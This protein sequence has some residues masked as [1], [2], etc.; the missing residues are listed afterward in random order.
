M[1][2]AYF[3]T[4]MIKYSDQELI[5]TQKIQSF[6]TWFESQ[7]SY[8][9]SLLQENTD[10]ED[11][12]FEPL[13]KALNQIQTDLFFLL[14]YKVDEQ[15][16]LILTA[17][18]NIKN[19]FLIDALIM[20]A[21]KIPDW[22]IIG[23]KKPIELDQL[24]INIGAMV[25]D[26]NTLFFKPIVHDAYPDLIDIE[27]YFTQFDNEDI[28][29]VHQGIFI[30]LDNYIGELNFT[31][32][33]D[34]VVIIEEVP[35]DVEELVPIGKLKDYLNWREKE[36]LEVYELEL[37]PE[38]FHY[39]LL[40]AELKDGGILLAIINTDALKLPARA[41]LPWVGV[42]TLTFDLDEDLKFPNE[43]TQEKLEQ[44]ELELCDNLT[45][46]DAA[47]HIGR[48]TIGTKREIYFVAADYNRLAQVFYACADKH[49]EFK[50]ESEIYKDKYWRTFDKF[51]VE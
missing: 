27:I 9:K 16:E 39:T 7:A 36:F 6:W 20:H 28:N 3:Y 21:P 1:Q 35:K 11:L 48:Q 26:Q 33:I 31:K 51:C 13:G 38:E 8:F 40:S 41:A 29:A 23:H 22:K 19:M 37:L 24:Q 10:V 43:P 15:A 12:I 17:D 46:K 18:G 45:S 4:L 2:E 14:G 32:L 49:H 47:I 34:Q 42:V 50:L 44:I 25:F 5:P 30:F